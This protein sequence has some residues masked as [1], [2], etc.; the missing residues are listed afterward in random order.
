[1]GVLYHRRDPQE[2]LQRL[3]RHT[4]PGGTVFIETIILDTEETKAL[5]PDDRYA[6]M[7]NVWSIPSPN[8]VQDWLDQC[9]YTH[10][11]LHNMHKTTVEEQ[12]TTPWMSNYSLINFLDKSDLNKTIEG[13]P[14][15]VRAVF[16]AIRPS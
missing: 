5:I 10:I 16:S 2:H 12:H 4:K 11:Q 7:R 14:A 13:H 3:F 8:L 1:M 9:G 15:P 6:G